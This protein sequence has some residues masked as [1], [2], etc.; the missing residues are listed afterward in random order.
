MRSKFLVLICITSIML[1][2]CTTTSTESRTFQ[3]KDSTKTISFNESNVIESPQVSNK[4][5]VEFDELVEYLKSDRS[6][7]S[8][9][10]AE[11][12]WTNN[13]INFDLYLSD[14]SEKNDIISCKDFF[15]S[16]AVGGSSEGYGY[17]GKIGKFITDSEED[18][19]KRILRI[20]IDDVLFIKSSYTIKE[21][22]II[23]SSYFENILYSMTENS[24]YSTEHST[25]KTS[26][27][28][29]FP[30]Y[31]TTDYRTIY[32]KL[33]L[34]SSPSSTELEELK[35]SIVNDIDSKKQNLDSYNDIKRVIISISI[36]NEIN[37]VHQLEIVNNEYTWSENIWY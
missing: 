17:G 8:V 2:A 26:A 20:Y 32:G 18:I 5:Y 15:S 36:N 14:A 4:D 6:I 34:S 28:S 13:D 10:N 37:E 12:Y 25:I 31:K 22:K 21:S 24:L 30:L 35:M 9:S 1:V 23:D 11:I 27:S 3:Y 33:K 19:S 7:Q 16:F 29:N